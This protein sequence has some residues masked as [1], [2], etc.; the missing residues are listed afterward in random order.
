M[1][2]IVDMITADNSGAYGSSPLKSF[3]AKRDY[4]ERHFLLM[5]SP[6]SEAH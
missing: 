5:A 6:T 3:V 1:L 2:W 4:Q